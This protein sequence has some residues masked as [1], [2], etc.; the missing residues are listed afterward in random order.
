MNKRTYRPTFRSG[1]IGHAS[2]CVLAAICV[3]PSL[4]AAEPMVGLLDVD[5]PTLVKFDSASPQKLTATIKVRGL[6][7]NAELLAIDFRSQTGELFGLGN[8]SRIYKIDEKTGT[9]SAVGTGKMNP[10]LDL[11]AKGFGFDCNP[12]N[13]E[14]RISSESRQ[15][16]VFDL[17]SGAVV[18]G[19]PYSYADPATSAIRDSSEIDLVGLAF[20]AGTDAGS[21]VLYGIDSNFNELVTVTGTGGD[22]FQLTPVPGPAT[23]DGNT[24]GI[25]PDDRVGFDISPTSGAAFVV[26]EN[27]P[28]NQALYSLDLGS[29]RLKTVGDTKE[30]LRD[31]AAGGTPGP[32]DAPGGSSSG[33]VS[34]DGGTKGAGSSGSGSANDGPSTIGGGAGCSST[35]APH[36]G[37][38][39][40][41]L[42]LGLGLAMVRVVRRRGR[43]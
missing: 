7:D 39:L 20:S 10:P 28:A 36:A 32:G 22:F 29:G 41:S 16:L 2:L 26:A 35:P 14:V 5:D 27:G 40:G 4:A 13:D 43:R 33:G 38:G 18:S 25:E 19:T 34:A 3:V 8:D 23:K 21:A 1:S 42:V 12:R 30:E 24:L 6:T 37:W 17:K 9:A 15:N 11:D 31:L